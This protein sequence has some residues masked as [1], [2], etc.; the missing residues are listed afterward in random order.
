MITTE[1]GNLVSRV[2]SLLR[3]STFSKER[4]DPGNEV[5]SSVGARTSRTKSKNVASFTSSR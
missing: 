4:K 5:E 2:L 1:Q 3:E